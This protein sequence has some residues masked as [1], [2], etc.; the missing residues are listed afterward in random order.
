M[1]AGPIVFSSAM[2]YYG[3]QEGRVQLNSVQCAGTELRLSD[4]VKETLGNQ[5]GCSTLGGYS[6]LICKGETNYCIIVTEH[7]YHGCEAIWVTLQIQVVMELQGALDI[8]DWLVEVL[9]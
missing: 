6:Y 1:H 2:Q 7:I 5:I 8:P 3:A 9:Q 4:C